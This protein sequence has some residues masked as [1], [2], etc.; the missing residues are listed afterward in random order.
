LLGAFLGIVGAIA[1][2]A[3]LGALLHRSWSKPSG[4]QA[5]RP[6]SPFA[7][8]R[9][10]P[11]LRLSEARVVDIAKQNGRVLLTFDAPAD[12]TTARQTRCLTGRPDPGTVARLE[13][14][15]AEGTALLLLTDEHGDTHVL[16]RDGAATGVRVVSAYSSS[17]H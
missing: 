8:P 4:H 1:L 11:P 6:P 10:C 12:R 14:W 17:A 9:R 3:G 5:G 13:R 16:S 2:V 7:W 15:C